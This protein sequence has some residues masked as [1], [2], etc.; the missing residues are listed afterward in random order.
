MSALDDD[1]EGG[2]RTVELGPG[3]GAITSR[4]WQRYPEASTCEEMIK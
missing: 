2:Q 3:T 4:L 1:S